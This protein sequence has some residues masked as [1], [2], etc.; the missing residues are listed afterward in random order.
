MTQ[1]EQL[2]EISFNLYERYILLE[3]IG[4]L[5][6]P[7]ESRY[8]VLDVGGHT[9]AFW[10]GFS[11]LTGVLIPDADV[12]VVDMQ[13]AADLKNYV[14]SSGFALP[15][16]DGTF[17]LVCSLDTLEHI[18]NQHR[19]AFLAELL[20]VTRDGLYLAFPFDSPS[21]RWA[22]SL[23]VEYTNVLL[24]QPVPA[25]LER[26]EFGLPDKD[27]VNETFASAPYPWIGFAQS[28]TDVWLLMMLTYHTLR[29]A[30]ADFVRELNRRFNQAYASQDWSD[31]CYRAGYLLSK[32]RPIADLERLRAS[33]ALVDQRA[34]L[35]SVLLLCQLF[36]TI[37]QNTRVTVD[38]DR[39]IRNIES[40]LARL[41]DHRKPSEESAINGQLQLIRDQI[42][43]LQ[44]QLHI[45]EVEDG[46]AVDLDAG[47]AG[48]KLVA[49]RAAGAVSRVRSLLLRVI[50]RCV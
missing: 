30:G 36:L 50:G 26:Q 49:G 18:P 19:T 17:D 5:F 10:S 37:S 47:T 22:E 16:R 21:N 27:R 40:E 46:R 1:S 3:R 4:K 2:R 25:L 28:N 20:R 34:D 41:P 9:P 13:P 14:R 43:S 11:S 39:H 45:S 24:K 12:T 15:F 32:F 33:F 42:D 38:K 48:R 31:P 23:V 6:R 44:R 7:A 29:K 35:Q 8:R